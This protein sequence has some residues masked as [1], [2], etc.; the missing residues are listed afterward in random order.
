M[1]GAKEPNRCRDI[2]LAQIGNSRFAGMPEEKFIAAVRIVLSSGPDRPG[3]ANAVDFGAKD[4]IALGE[5]VDLVHVRG[6][7]RFAPSR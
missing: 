6:H 5:A 1:N 2:R 3:S 4:E 7:F